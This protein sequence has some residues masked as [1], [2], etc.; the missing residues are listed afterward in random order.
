MANNVAISLFGPSI[1]PEL[2][3]RLYRSLSSN[4]V[5]FE[6]IFVGNRLPDF[7]LPN[8]IHF[9]YSEVK[10]AQCAEI[11]RHIPLAI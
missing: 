8:N 2:W 3:M 4:A 7:S 6:I 1:R 9:I 10:P 11:A 5:P